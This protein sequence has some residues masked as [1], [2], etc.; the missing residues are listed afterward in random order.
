[1]RLRALAPLV[2]LA[3]ACAGPSSRGSAPAPAATRASLPDGVVAEVG[4]DLIHAA[5]VAR[6]AAAQ[7]LTLP[8]ARERAIDDALL[9]AGA[10]SRLANTGRVT[11]AERGAL[12]RA[13][14]E[15]LKRKARAQGPPTD[16]EIEHFTA[17]HWFDLDRP[18]MARTVHAVIVP[19]SP[20]QDAAA[21]ALAD[22]VARAVAGISDPAEFMK[23]AQA[24]PHDKLKLVVEALEPCTSDG[25]VH[26]SQPLPPGVPPPRFDEDFAQAANAIDKVGDQSPV[27]KLGSGY[28]VILLV[29]KLPEKRVPLDERRA[30]LTVEIMN[31]R[32]KAAEDQLLSRLSAGVPVQIARS[33]LDLTS[34]VR[35]A[36]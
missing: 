23:K 9:A 32:A 36:R 14:L 15:D 31:S 25:R 24:V 6:I 1:M 27:L 11:S 2:L 3:T 30:K 34:R 19:K 16:A 20:T 33:A 18:P 13:V 8:A 29:Q 10:R 28:H 5:T 35:I 4:G 21:K 17:E 22:R 7:G 26:P 12:A